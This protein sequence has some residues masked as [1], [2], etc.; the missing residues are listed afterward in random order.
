M[1][2]GEHRLAGA[3][4]VLVALH[5]VD[6]AVVGDEPVRVGERPRRE[7]VRREPAV[8]E[9]ESALET[10]VG[11]VGEELG[12]LRRRQHPLVDE[13]ARR[14]RGQVRGDVVVEL[15]LDALA[16][17]ERLAVELDPG[18]RPASASRDDELAEPRHH[19]PR[20]HAEAVGMHRH[21]APGDD[22]QAFVVDDALDRRLG[23][24]GGERL[25]RQERQPDGVLPGRRQHVAELA[26]EEAVGHLDED[27]GAVTRVGL[28]PGRPAVVEVGQRRQGR[29]DE[30]AADDALQ[31]GDEGHTARVVL[32]AGVVEAMTLGSPAKGCAA[33]GCRP[34][35]RKSNGRLG[36]CPGRHLARTVNRQSRGST[37]A[38]PY[39]LPRNQMGADVTE[40]S[41]LDDTLSVR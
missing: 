38:A 2:A 23:L 4:P 30:L 1:R 32:E 19:R 36:W 27:P 28:G 16:H 14:Q 3:H 39:S 21:V 25:D 11:E 9:G 24:L 8:H 40:P 6:L 15:V 31:M 13:R 18:A 20:R 35:P 26:A 34:R 17:D 29:V 22:T 7:R 41:C 37:L 5:G 12:E 33:F 10:L